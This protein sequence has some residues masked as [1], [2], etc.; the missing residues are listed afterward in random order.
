M[1]NPTLLANSFESGISIA[2]GPRSVSEQASRRTFI[3]TLAMLFVVCVAVTT[4]WC[5]S[6]SATG[7]M[8]M[9]GGW[10]MS[11]GWVRMPGPTRAG[12]TASFVGMWVVIDGCDDAAIVGAGIGALPPVR[13]ADAR[14][15]PRPTHHAGRPRLLLRLDT[16]GIGRFPGGRGD[17]NDRNGAAGGGA[18][19]SHRGRIGRPHRRRTPVHKVEGTSPHLLPGGAGARLRAV[20]SPRCGVE[21]GLAFRTPLRPQL[22]QLDGDP[23]GCRCHGP[24]HNGRHHG[25]YHR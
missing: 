21:A 4:V 20:D 25:R 11:M 2:T 3:G 23:F 18:R 6:M 8:P 22:R 15:V 24:A 7:E 10:T 5:N 9:P 13:L 16:V 19:C 14:D 12:A 17:G 1:K